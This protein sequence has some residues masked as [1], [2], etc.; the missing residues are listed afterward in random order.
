MGGLLHL[1]QR[2]GY[3]AGL[4]SVQAPL[5]CTKCNSLPING[6]C[7]N[8]CIAVYMLYMSVALRF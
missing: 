3:W 8:H 2:G 5:P 1:V 4:Q 6:E 7:A